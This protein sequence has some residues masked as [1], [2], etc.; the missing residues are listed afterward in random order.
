MAGPWVDSATLE[1]DVKDILKLSEDGT[2]EPYWLRLIEKARQ[3]GYTDLT[4][5]L[6]GRGYTIA[7]LDAWDN[8]EVYNRQQAL[9]WLY[10]E[11]SLGIGYDDKEINKLDRRPQLLKAAT[12]M[13]NGVPVVPGGPADTGGSVGGGLIS[14][15]GYRI[16]GSTEF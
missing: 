10:T 12:I 3:T 7:Q 11:S 5:I 14:E 6:L 4:E 13:V 16:N 15:C 8:R 1:Q 9:F 2:L